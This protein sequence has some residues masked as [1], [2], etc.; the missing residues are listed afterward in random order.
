M[1]TRKS[2][3]PGK[4]VERYEL[5]S[6]TADFMSVAANRSR[7]GFTPSSSPN[8]IWY[9]SVFTPKLTAYK[10]A[11]LVWVNPMT[12]TV[13]ALDNLKDAENAL[14]PFYQQFYGIVRTSP[15]VTDGDL[16]AMGFPRR[17]SGDHTHHPVDKLFIDLNVKP[18][19]NLVLEVAFEDRDTGS[20]NIPYYL[21]GAVLYYLAGDAPVTSQDK[22]TQSQLASR[23]P[24]EL[25][26]PPGQSGQTLSIA[27]RWQNRLGELGPWSDIVSVI[28]P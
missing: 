21:N 13:V 18:L 15:V 12:S 6:K 28:I 4:R 23:S 19:G 22:L 8:G 14:F 27:G 1:A 11:Y 10:T 5:I 16:E 25:T 24:F 26:F 2:W 9:D 17:P 3:F 7:I 20:P